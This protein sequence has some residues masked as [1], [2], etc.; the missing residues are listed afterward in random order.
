MFCHLG[1]LWLPTWF[2]AKIFAC[3][4][5]LGK[6]NV[7]K[8][9]SWLKTQERHAV[10]ALFLHLPW[11]LSYLQ[12]CPKT[13]N[14]LMIKH[15]RWVLQ[16]RWNNWILPSRYG[17]LLTFLRLNITRITLWNNFS[18]L[19]IKFRNKTWRQIRYLGQNIT[20]LQISTFDANVTPGMRKKRHIISP[21]SQTELQDI[22]SSKKP[23]INV[24]SGPKTSKMPLS[25]WDTGV[26]KF[27][28]RKS[29]NSILSLPRAFFIVRN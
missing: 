2:S 17:V 14:W 7:L 10:P 5:S 15:Y 8:L 18:G 21:G 23:W 16:R 20:N 4:C 19:C 29:Q 9:F 27:N 28:E 3:D 25:S 22:S 26:P 1:T 13:E 12:H 6:T 24:F 11:F